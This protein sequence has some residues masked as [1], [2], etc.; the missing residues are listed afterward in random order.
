[1]QHAQGHLVECVPRSRGQGG[2]SWDPSF[3]ACSGICAPPGEQASLHSPALQY[4]CNC[5]SSERPAEKAADWSVT[6]HLDA[7]L[8]GSLG[9]AQE[10]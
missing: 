7:A 5:P 9:G 8:A 1:M 6:G 4:V 3:T 10:K 2:L